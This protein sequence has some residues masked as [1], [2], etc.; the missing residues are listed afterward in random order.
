[1]KNKIVSK[2]FVEAIW[3]TSKELNISLL[4]TAEYYSIISTYRYFDPRYSS[5]PK[6]KYWYE[7]ILPKYDNFRFKTALRVSR[8]HFNLIRELLSVNPIFQTR[9]TTPL[10]TKLA[11]TL[12]RFGC[13]G[14]GSSYMKVGQLFGISDGG[15]IISFTN[16][17]IQVNPFILT[18]WFAITLS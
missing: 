6:S 18:T 8:E 15:A 13:D 4:E 3:G 14:S 11:I 17:V 9:N 12:Y 2:T 5:V 16:Q 1:M 7:R 10:E